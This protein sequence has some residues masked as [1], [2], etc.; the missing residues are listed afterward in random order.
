M[1]EPFSAL[2]VFTAE[3]LRSEVYKLWTAPVAAADGKDAPAKNGGAGGIAHL[4][5]VMIITHIIEE[6]VFLADRIVIMGTRPGHIRK[7]IE[8]DL[9]HPR[10]YQSSAFLEM[11]QQLHDII[12]S[13]HLPETPATSAGPTVLGP[14]PL[15]QV[16]LGEVFGLMEVLRDRG[17]RADVFGLD[18]VTEYDF[19]HTLSVI[20]AGEMLALLDTPRN[21]VA[22][23]VLGNKLLDKD[24]NDRKPLINRQLRTLNTFKFILKIVE[25]CPN[26]RLTK[27][28]ILEELVMRLPTEDVEKLFETVVSW[29]RFAELFVYEVDTET[30]SLDGGD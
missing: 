21:N 26:K 10:D 14:E 15:P 16:Q 6:A 11:V 9:E 19:G 25:E 1:D 20:K 27:D 2:D 22:L 28:I 3:S 8:N 30:L 4:K 17:G 5:S 23:T 18:M 13:E 7:I 29:G 12:V 24:I